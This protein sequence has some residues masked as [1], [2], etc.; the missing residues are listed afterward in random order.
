MR[1]VAI[2]VVTCAVS[3]SAALI[4]SSSFVSWRMDRVEARLQELEGIRRP[5]T[6][7]PAVTIVDVSDRSEAGQ[8]TAEVLL[9]RQSPV[10]PIV[11]QEKSA[12]M[13]AQDAVVGAAVA[14]SADGWLVTT[15]GV[16]SGMR[17]AEIG[18]QVGNVVMPVERAVKDLSTD[19]VFLRVASVRFSPAAFVR[20]ET[21]RSGQRA[22]IEPHPRRVYADRIADTR[23]GRQVEPLSSE[24]AG[25][26]FFLGR[27]DVADWKGG[28][29][30]DADGRLV[31]LLDRQ[32]RDGWLVLPAESLGQ[33]FVSLVASG[34]VRRAVLGVRA[35]DLTGSLTES[36]STELPASGALVAGG[37]T[38][39]VLPGGPASG[40]LVEGD[41]IVRLDRDLLDGSAD[42][43]ERL[44]AYRPGANVVV[45][46]IRG[47]KTLEIPLTLGSAVVTESIK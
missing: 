28:A 45:G 9:R 2:A 13:I 42:L 20:A 41:V 7:Q 23:I 18:V 6:T 31:G 43:G 8:D 24:R 40:K 44:L 21:V 3:V 39:A 1:V 17:L 32:T 29:V 5:T 16:V 14:V 47:G 10:Y 4:G 15:A 22:W 35:V 38:P 11:K 27:T 37:K 46:V 26:R 12:G 25:R 36:A 19:A 33:T 34:E 30:W